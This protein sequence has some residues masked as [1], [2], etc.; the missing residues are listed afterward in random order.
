MKYYSTNNPDRHCTFREAVL[1]GLPDDNGLF[2]PVDIPALPSA[3]L[4]E[5]AELSP[6]EIGFE[7]SSRYTGDDI[8]R[9]E[10]K[11]ICDDAFNFDVPV[12]KLDEKTFIAELFHGPTLAFKDFGARFM[13]KVMS[14]LN[15]NEKK[16]LTILVATSGD[17]GGAVADGFFNVDGIEVFILYPSGGVSDLQEKQLTTH[18]NNIHAIEI[19]GS[20]DDC[21]RLVKTAFLD[22]EIASEYR[23]SSANSINISRLIPQMVYYF[24]SFGKV[25][26]PGMKTDFVVPSGNFGNLSAGLLAK[27]MG[28][29]VTH[30][31][32]ATNLN[33]TFPQFLEGKG[34]SPKKSVQTLS[35][36]MDVGNPSNF[37]RMNDLFHSH[38]EEF[39]KEI[40]GFIISD[41][42]TEEI[43]RRI[44]KRYKYIAD[45]HGAVGIGAWNKY[46]ENHPDETGIILETAHPAKFID[47]VERVLNISLPLPESLQKISVKKKKA[48]LLSSDFESLKEYLLS[49]RY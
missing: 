3:V 43:I 6:A 15:R 12:V 16:L 22:S 4:N 39:R 34:F 47:V 1:K 44:F 36:A 10:L 30:F 42:E 20:F 26:R 28:L 38:L 37:S 17:T 2:M 18:G 41:Q 49:I 9:D 5:L 23:L 48:E 33:D 46:S 8:P 31:I 7:V 21:Q 40:S 14:Y 29:P 24:T 32:A 35:N 45:P 11:R 19:K 13:A 27:R 25:H